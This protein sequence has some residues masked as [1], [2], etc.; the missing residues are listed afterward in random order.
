MSHVLVTALPTSATGTH[1]QPGPGELPLP[2][3]PAALRAHLVRDHGRTDGDLDDSTLDAIHAL[4]HFDYGGGLV[5][6]SHV[7][8]TTPTT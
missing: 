6:A 7:H 1:E 5:V 3:T 2:D 4:E 8:R